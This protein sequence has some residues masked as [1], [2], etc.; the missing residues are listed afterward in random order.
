MRDTEESALFDLNDAVREAISTLSGEF[1]LSIRL[2]ADFHP[3][4]LMVRGQPQRLHHAVAHVLRNAC[5]SMPG[6]GDVVVETGVLGDPGQDQPAARCG[7]TITDRGVGIPED[8]LPRIYEPFFTTKDKCS[9]LGLSVAYSA[10]TSVGGLLDVESRLGKGTQV[11]IGLPAAGSLAEA[12][13]DLVAPDR[14]EKGTVLVVDD[15]EVIRDLA[16]EI[17]EDAGHRVVVVPG[18]REALDVLGSGSSDVE[19]VIM[20]LAMPG[21]T[22]Q[23]TVRTL[24]ERGIRVP[25]LISS[26]FVGGPPGELLASLDA[27]G[28]VPKPYEIAELVGAVERIL[29]GCTVAPTSST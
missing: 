28:F 13:E 9:G 15:E 11:V 3:E 2:R 8:V 20:D 12:E 19:L 27:Q 16:Q 7:I 21:M 23:E 18:G 26:G 6:G 29:S 22:G 4:P 24:R 14:G 25:V 5:E 10:L 17:L 1:D